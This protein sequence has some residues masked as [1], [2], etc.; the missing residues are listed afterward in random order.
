MENLGRTKNAAN[1]RIVSILVRLRGI[2]RDH[3][4]NE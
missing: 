2:L 3:W 1:G 4:I